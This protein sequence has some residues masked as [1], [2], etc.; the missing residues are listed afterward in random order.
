MKKA[1][2][3]ARYS[4]DN[5]REESI[6][7]QLRICRKHCADKGYV[8]I[9]EYV[10][11]AYTATNDNRPSYQ[12][13]LRDSKRHDFQVAVFHKVNRNA[14]NEYDY[15]ANKAK[16]ISNGVSVEY[17]GQS[18]DTTTA[19]GQLME[20]Q[21]VGMAA[22]FSRNLARE[23]KKGQH[24]NA[25]KCVHNGG[26]PPLGY[27]VSHVTRR[28]VVNEIE[29]DIVRFIFDAYA[30]GKKY[31]D[32]ISECKRRAYKTKRGRDFGYNSLH[33]LLRNKK[34]IGVYTYGRARGSR[35]K[36]RNSH[37]NSEDVIEIEG[38][39][40]SIVSID[41]WSR[42]QDRLDGKIHSKN[43]AHAKAVY[44]LSGLIVCGTCGHQMSANLCRRKLKDGSKRTHRYYRCRTCKDIHIEQQKI[45]SY[46]ISV[47]KRNITGKRKIKAIVSAINKELEHDDSKDKDELKAIRKEIASIDR[48]NDNLMQIIEDGQL[49]SII[50]ERLMK[51]AERV[52]ALRVREAEIASANHDIITVEE[53]EAVLTAWQHVNDA[54]G[55]K[56][57][58]QTFV[59]S[60]TV[61]STHIDVDL[62]IAMNG[63]HYTAKELT[64]SESKKEI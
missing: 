44:L 4:S 33:D 9:H 60:V 24:E 19:E 54:E 25:L 30:K 53:V 64:T 62:C 26:T 45:E 34:Y 23:V 18:F 50:K 48:A 2:I 42:V 46:V 7:A 55:L 57:M 20:N 40:P 12:Q 11:E 10:D 6:D 5:Q 59:K 49:S 35:N 41:T 36:P 63:I 56:A 27:D 17:A 13:M 39:L 31:P 58:L 37:K 3:Y 32:I 16:L 1:V 14:R 15:Y 22:Y 52:K 43:G 21:L 28:Y 29:A 8:I 47:V 51:N 38:G 61:Y